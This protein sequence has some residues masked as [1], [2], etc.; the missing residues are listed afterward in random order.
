MDSVHSQYVK[1]A[2]SPLVSVAMTYLPGSRPKYWRAW[3]VPPTLSAH[4]Q[5]TAPRPKRVRG[6]LQI[7]TTIQAYTMRKAKGRFACRNEYIYIYIYIYAYICAY[8]RFLTLPWFSSRRQDWFAG[9]GLG[10]VT[11]NR[12]LSGQALP[13]QGIKVQA[14]TLQDLWGMPG[15]LFHPESP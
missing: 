8:A 11:R 5:T 7:E 6:D 14:N 9:N 15:E 13:A 12:V 1:H 3:A 4:F 2:L 10:S